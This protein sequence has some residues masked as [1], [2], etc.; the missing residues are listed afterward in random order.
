MLAAL[1]FG[2]KLLV[3]GGVLSLLASL[4]HI[5]VIIGGPDW[6]RFFGAGEDMARMAEKGS[7]YPTL[8]TIGIAAILAIWSWFAFAGAGLVWKPPLLRAGLIAIS[9][10]YLTR[11]L[12]L[13]PMTLLAPEK[14]N[15]F[16]IWSSA[17]VLVYG[18]FYA[19]GT[20]KSW[21]AF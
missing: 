16:A 1:D 11:G 17:I 7:L 9:A 12:V 18:L 8:I 14:I 10:I 15:G 3:V 13:L 6:Y 4:L 21:S 5:G 2:Q 19:V 20:W